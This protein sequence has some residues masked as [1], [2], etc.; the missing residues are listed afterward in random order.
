[1]WHRRVKGL[2]LSLQQL[3]VVPT[4]VRVRSLAWEF[5]RVVGT[6]PPT[7]NEHRVYPV[8][9]ILCSSYLLFVIRMYYLLFIALCSKVTKPLI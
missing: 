5:P 3:D 2:T 6:L 4:V 7:S 8:I 1:M 9:S